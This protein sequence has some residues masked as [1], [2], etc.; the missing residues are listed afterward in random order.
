MLYRFLNARGI[1]LNKGGTAGQFLDVNEISSYA[2]EAVEYVR[3]SGVVNGRPDGSFAPWTAP[4]VRRPAA[5]LQ[6][7]QTRCGAE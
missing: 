3:R 4:P 6:A 7:S 1:S 5:C 2:A